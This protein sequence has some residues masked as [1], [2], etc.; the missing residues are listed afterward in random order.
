MTEYSAEDVIGLRHL[1]D[2]IAPDHKESGGKMLENALKG[3]YVVDNFECPI[4]G[5]SRSLE[6]L[7]NIT[8]QYDEAGNLMG[9]VGIGI[10]LNYF[11]YYLI[12][13]LYRS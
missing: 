11:P 3:T 9:A 13:M 4:E 12:L 8:C 7:L 1:E 6:V 5:R 2:F 10:R